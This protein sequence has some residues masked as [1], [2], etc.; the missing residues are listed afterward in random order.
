MDKL[1]IAYLMGGGATSVMNLA[2]L[3]IYDQAKESEKIGKISGIWD[4][5]EGLVYDSLFKRSINIL[6][7][8]RS[9]L[10]K[11]SN[12]PGASLRSGRRLPDD[13]Q[14]TKI[15]KQLK[16]NKINYLFYHGGN[17][18][19]LILS[20]II[21]KAHDLDINL[22]CIH[23]PKTIDNDLMGT[24]FS[25][26]YGTSAKKVALEAM[27][28]RESF[29]ASP[30]IAVF[31][32]MGRNAGWLAAAAAAGGADLI[33]FPERPVNLDSFCKQVIAKHIENLAKGRGT[34]VA[35]SEGIINKKGEY[36]AQIARKE[37]NATRLSDEYIYTP[38]LSSA[39]LDFFLKEKIKEE[40]FEL[41]N[42]KFFD[43]KVR[44]STLGYGQRE[45]ME[46]I[47]MTDR[48][49][50]Y[51]TGRYAIKFAVEKKTSVMVGI[52]KS[53]KKR[54]QK[55]L[56]TVK[57][58]VSYLPERLKDISLSENQW[59]YEP[60]NLSKVAD[61][62]KDEVFERK[63][64][65]KYINKKGNNVTKKFL[66]EYLTP[67]IGPIPKKYDFSKPNLFFRIKS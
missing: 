35:V 26:G 64:P 17:G 49:V 18:T 46:V 52:K 34:V 14:F 45:N 53:E 38:R 55:K 24:Y 39:P 6:D 7:L 40:L 59:I 13:K 10:R 25:P 42:L 22:R 56:I 44:A 67:I 2:I 12:M 48:E 57:D 19:A 47:C 11:I 9:T 29:N 21:K 41:E 61:F 4:G 20:R 28:L 63:L 65:D 51:E 62:K 15:V 58:D 8:D 23:I 33:Y 54:K 60:V 36:F 37:L 16:K 50:A 31:I 3:G 30:G 1:N 27:N 66:K 5:T 32:T 43:T